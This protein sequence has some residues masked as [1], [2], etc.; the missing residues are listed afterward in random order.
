[1]SIGQFP[2]GAFLYF[3]YGLT[4]IFLGLAIAVK[5][6]SES[7][8][9]LA[10]SLP[11]LAVFGFSHGIHEWCETYLLLAHGGSS[12]ELFSVHYL[13]LLTLIVS[14]LFL[15]LFAISL[16]RTQPQI[17]WQWLK[18]LIPLLFLFL[19]GYYWV[20]RDDE[21]LINIET[22]S[23]LA[24]G[25]LGAGLTG[26]ALFVHA[27]GVAV[28]NRSVALNLRCAGAAFGCYAVLTGL[29]PSYFKFPVVWIPVDVPVEILRSIAAV[30]ITFFMV[31][32]LNIFNLETRRELE[33]QL[34][35]L[36]QTEKLAA[37]GKLAAG[38]AHEIN[39]PLANASLNIQTLRARVENSGAEPILLRKL[40]AAENN[41]D[42]ASA[43]AKDLLHL[44]RK[45][46][47]SQGQQGFALVDLNKI[48][49]KAVSCLSYRL[50]GIVIQQE[51]SPL[52]PVQGEAGKL[53][54]VFVNI[55]TN[56]IEAMETGGEIKLKS[57]MELP[58]VK[59]ELSDTGYGIPE[60]LLLQVCDPFFTTKEVGEGTGLGL[61]IS[62]GIIEQH[63][64]SIEINSV[65]GKG[66]TIS[67]KIPAG[68]R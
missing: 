47:V 68:T 45:A 1:M 35:R 26:Y 28:F 51:L 56:A 65:V 67:I 42:R 29:I 22:F 8:L 48:L 50:K 3:V 33:Q 52:A 32:G 19:A 15:N 36:G 37:L 38:I 7:R 6:M 64:G 49:E 60:E 59:V 58:W 44:A 24:L 23:R 34:R 10:G 54:Q 25:T 43:I 5:D 4:F 16:L 40:Q 39:N 31:R 21:L 20:A 61:A 17:R 62:H 57:W 12:A 55:L 66:T 27:K 41:I 11:Y 53:Q 30:M 63:N 13:R 14:F 9:K 46:P 2:P 18:G